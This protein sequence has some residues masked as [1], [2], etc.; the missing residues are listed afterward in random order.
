VSGPLRFR[1]HEEDGTFGVFDSAGPQVFFAETRERALA[2][3]ARANRIVVQYPLTVSMRHL[4]EMDAAWRRARGLPVPE[5]PAGMRIRV[6]DPGGGTPDAPARGPAGPPA[7]TAAA[8]ADVARALELARGAAARRSLEDRIATEARVLRTAVRF[9]REAEAV[10]RELTPELLRLRRALSGAWGKRA[11]AAEAALWR[12]AARQASTEEVLP[13]LRAATDA[14]H[15]SDTAPRTRDMR[16]GAEVAD[17]LERCAPLLVRAARVL[18]SEAA[19]RVGP[20]PAVDLP[21]DVRLELFR[22]VCR[23][24]ASG[25]RSALA[26]L[27]SL[28]RRSPDVSGLFRRMWTPLP[29]VEREAIRSAVPEMKAVLSEREGTATRSPRAR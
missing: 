27:R 28:Y 15:R 16:A 4:R 9:E 29:A 19:H 7:G 11:E 21:P 10:Q 1:L 14:L 23:A 2:E 24:S 13:A 22:D 20:A 18:E 12:A 26:E 25:A 3:V 6:A 5:E 8:Q 17:A